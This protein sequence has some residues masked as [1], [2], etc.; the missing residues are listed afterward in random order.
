MWHDILIEEYNSSNELTVAK[1]LSYYSA[2][3]DIKELWNE[4]TRDDSLVLQFFEL[5]EEL[6]ENQ[7]ILGYDE[8]INHIIFSI[9][10]NFDLYRSFIDVVYNS[11]RGK[12]IIQK[13][14]LS[15]F[16]IYHSSDIFTSSKKCFRDFK[17][18]IIF[19]KMKEYLEGI[20]QQRKISKIF[21]INQE[22]KN[23]IISNH[24]SII[25]SFILKTLGSKLTE[26]R[27]VESFNLI[28]QI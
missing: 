24:L 13:N 17:K 6:N 28:K 15:F 8:F 14:N 1:H 20:K 2:G 10:E 22:D 21:L 12:E 4:S 11:T 7:G 26:Q 9:P 27:E 25:N 23:S 16:P 3:S 18:T 5:F 19:E